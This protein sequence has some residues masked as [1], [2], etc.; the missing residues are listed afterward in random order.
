MPILRKNAPPQQA[1]CGIQRDASLPADASE[2][3]AAADYCEAENYH[4]FIDPVLKGEYPQLVVERQAM[5]MPMIPAA[6]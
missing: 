6:I 1:W 2:D 3:Q 5:N 4:W